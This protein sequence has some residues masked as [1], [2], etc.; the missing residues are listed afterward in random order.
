V[1]E[2]WTAPSGRYQNEVYLLPKKLDEFVA[3]AHL[4]TFDAQLT[5]MSDEQAQYLGVCKSGPFKPHH[6]KCVTK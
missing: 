1:K 2:L 4:T 5:E 6:Y 3:R